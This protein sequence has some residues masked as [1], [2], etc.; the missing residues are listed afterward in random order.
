MRTNSRPKAEA[1][2]PCGLN[3]QI[4]AAIASGDDARVAQ[5]RSQLASGDFG[6]AVLD[7]VVFQD[8]IHDL[9]LEAVVEQEGGAMEDVER[10]HA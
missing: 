9:S 7:A 10:G 5:L 4:R 6:G 3:D 1:F 8:A 2:R